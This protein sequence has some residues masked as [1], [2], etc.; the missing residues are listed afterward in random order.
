[1]IKTVE[2][3]PYLPEQADAFGAVLA[4]LGKPVI[5]AVREPVHVSRQRI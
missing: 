4:E 2:R 1:M 3:C 5:P